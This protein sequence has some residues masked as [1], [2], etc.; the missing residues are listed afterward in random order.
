[1]LKRG[2]SPEDGVYCGANPAWYTGLSPA[3]ALGTSDPQAKKFLDLTVE[4]HKADWYTKFSDHPGRPGHSSAE[5][6]N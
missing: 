4:A 5:I 1:M 6:R 3:T 2:T